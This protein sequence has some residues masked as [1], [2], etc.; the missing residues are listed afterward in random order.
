MGANPT[1][2]TISETENVHFLREPTAP[3]VS[4][5]LA[6]LEARMVRLEDAVTHA[7]R[8]L[9]HLGHG[10][11]ITDAPSACRQYP[12]ESD[13]TSG[14][15]SQTSGM[16][17]SLR[18][19]KKRK[20]NGEAFVSGKST[21]SPTGP[22]LWSRQRAGFEHSKAPRS[23]VDGHDLIQ[24]QL[25]HNSGIGNLQQESFKSALALLNEALKGQPTTQQAIDDERQA[26]G[27][28]SARLS[29]HDWNIPPLATIQWMLTS[30]FL[31]IV[32]RHP[33]TYTR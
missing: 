33:S 24:D 14:Q 16:S 29:K 11:D 5:A 23:A 1:V 19:S 15:Q 18:A 32:P 2:W 17:A 9:P 13:I 27:S 3:D 20:H 22:Q 25:V 4:A 8:Y 6:T 10:C 26:W 21:S 7:P 31:A 30:G 28:G 12:S